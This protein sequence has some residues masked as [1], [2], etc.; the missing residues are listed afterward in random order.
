MS[1]YIMLKNYEDV[2]FLSNCKDIYFLK[3]QMLVPNIQIFNTFI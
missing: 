2:I 3:F 1:E